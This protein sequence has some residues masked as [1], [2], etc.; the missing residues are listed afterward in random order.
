MV[1]AAPGFETMYGAEQALVGVGC[2]P[3]DKLHRHAVDATRMQRV[4]RLAVRL[5][6]PFPNDK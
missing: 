6:R 4:S 5:L 3:H 2:G 1:N